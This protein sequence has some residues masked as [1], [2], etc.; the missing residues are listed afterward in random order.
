[1]DF[2]VAVDRV[3]GAEDWAAAVYGSAMEWEI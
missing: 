3:D 2:S 1:L